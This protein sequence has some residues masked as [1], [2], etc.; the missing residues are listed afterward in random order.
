VSGWAQRLSLIQPQVF[1]GRARWACYE[2]GS[3]LAG[4]GTPENTGII[5]HKPGCGE[6]P[7]PPTPDTGLAAA[8]R[9]ESAILHQAARQLDDLVTAGVSAMTQLGRKT[10]DMAGYIRAAAERL[11]GQAGP[12]QTVCQ[13]GQKIVCGHGLLV[14]GVRYSVGGNTLMHETL[15]GRAEPCDRLWSEATLIPEAD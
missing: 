13:A 7:S 1:G 11:E 12:E 3:Y 6:L 2:C 15:T 4:D 9:A 14:T 5:E 10:S 8:I